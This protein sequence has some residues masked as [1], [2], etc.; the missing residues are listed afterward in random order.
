[1]L[2]ALLLFI[3]YLV[4]NILFGKYYY[5]R[6][7]FLMKK[8]F[9]LLIVGLFV[10]ITASSFAFENEHFKV[11]SSKW[12][13][14]KTVKDTYGFA[15]KNYEPEDPN[16]KM[17]PPTI[18]VGIKPIENGKKQYI[19]DEKEF[20]ESH[21]KQLEKE[22]KEAIK[23]IKETMI[24]FAMKAM[25][26]STKSQIEK[27]VEKEM[28]KE[29]SE[30]GSVFY[31]RIGE[32]KV[33]QGNYKISY[34]DIRNFY[35]ITLTK[36]FFIEIKHAESTDLDSLPAYKE[37]M[38]SLE[39]KDKVATKY[40]AVTL[41]TIITYTLWAVGLCLGAVIFFIVKKSM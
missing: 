17:F 36:N 3:T 15:L 16:M 27:M 30:L 29:E 22:Y 6:L 38:S 11:N 20:L 33:V 5:E 19:T 12:K 25:P 40:N 10:F 28:N 35:G 39:F 8:H 2:F 41:P 32:H 26:H 31:T 1:M 18:V 7:V 34:F 21:K 14:I 13:E 4:L 9:Y 24:S 37:F 23:T